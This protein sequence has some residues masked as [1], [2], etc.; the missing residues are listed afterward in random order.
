MTTTDL[1]VVLPGIMGSTLE[2]NG[3][4]VWD[5]SAG[6][7]V[8]AI[9]HFGRNIS[10]LQLPDG[11]GDEHP[12]DGVEP[13]SMLG[14][15]HVIPGLWTPVK[16]YDQTIAYLE[17]LGYHRDAPGKPGN[18]L[19]FPYDWRLSNRYN[20][21]RL[22]T[23]V[24]PALERWRAQGGKY[25]DARLVFVVH[26]MGGLVARWYIE[27]EGGAEV[28]RKL[29]TLG[30][31][32]RGSMNAISK[33]VAGLPIK[34]GPFTALN[35]TGFV[36][37]IPSLYQLMPEYACLTGPGGLAKTTEASLP[38]L[39]TAMVADAM[40]FHE[41]L[42]AAEAA[43][44][45]SLDMTHAIVGIK[46]P[47]DTTAAI[48][49]DAV[50]TYVD[51]QG[52]N[53]YGDGT[54][55]LTGAVRADLELDSNRLR[56]I[57]DQHGNLQCNKAALEEIEGILTGQDIRVRAPITIDPRVTVPEL[58]LA[59]EEL[60]VDVELDDNHRI[61]VT[62]KDERGAVVA[63]RVP[64]MKAGRA[65]ARFDDLAAGGYSVEVA[66]TSTGLPVST[67]TGTTLVW[68]PAA[69]AAMTG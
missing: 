42:K 53:L 34:V 57:A 22:K 28:T 52:T 65:T 60:P 23:V 3:K 51:Y 2:K 24:E 25:A 49:G 67:V 39:P 26:S 47:T 41:A 11:I 40:A 48:Q 31:P 4:P 54:V 10:A 62:L 37:S 18:L 7:L 14:D 15:L 36:R 33:L 30:T 1:V 66:G 45:A 59:G 9:L 69:D 38:N 68:D 8:Q 61:T 64:K 13:G 44:P 21:R 32:Y 50:V 5:V 35:L 12:G 20:G 19:P 29:V 56:R 6:A 16:G 63:T 55:P 43:R 46:Q 17:Q 58:V 27:Q